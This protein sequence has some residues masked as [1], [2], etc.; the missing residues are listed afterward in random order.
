MSTLDAAAADARIALKALQ[1][2]WEYLSAAYRP[3]DS[4]SARATAVAGLSA[5]YTVEAAIRWRDDPRVAVRLGAMSTLL[6]YAAQVITDDPIRDDRRPVSIRLARALA[7][8]NDVLTGHVDIARAW[9]EAADIAAADIGDA[10]AE[11][12]RV[13]G[14]RHERAG[15]TR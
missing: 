13:L 11:A 7:P 12:L 5:L 14:R 2:A 15:A 10:G 9:F 6:H 8:L 1:P 3:D 4:S